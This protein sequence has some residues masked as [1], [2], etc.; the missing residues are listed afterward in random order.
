MVIATDDDIVELILSHE[1][2]YSD[3]PQD[4]GG[5]TAWGITKLHHPEMW[6]DGPPTRDRA[7]RFYQRAYVAPF[8][9]VE[10]I[11]L[12]A[13]VVDIAVNS[14]LGTA[15]ALLAKAQQ[16]TERPASVQLVIERLKHYARIVKS[17]PSQSVFLLGWINRACAFLGLLLVLSGGA[18][19]SERYR[20]RVRIVD[21]PTW[22][23]RDIQFYQVRF[24]DGTAAVLSLDADLPLAKAIRSRLNTPLVLTLEPADLER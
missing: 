12:R 8:S 10:P 11:A 5:L 3:H 18:W 22:D 7:K 6:L 21:M 19:A 2:P 14:G 15:R 20:V 9:H 17:K 13:Q 4:R 16:Q 24:R 23:S 1:G